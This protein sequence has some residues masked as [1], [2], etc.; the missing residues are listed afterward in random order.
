MFAF[1]MVAVLLEM[2]ACSILLAAGWI[3]R[4]YFVCKKP[5]SNQDTKR[6]IVATLT[7]PATFRESNRGQRKAESGKASVLKGSFHCTSTAP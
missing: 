1:E 5:R 3:F 2:H 7:A 4:R 6:L